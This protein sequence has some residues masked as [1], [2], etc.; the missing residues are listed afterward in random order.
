MLRDKKTT[1]GDPYQYFRLQ[2]VGR[3]TDPM[4]LKTTSKH[5]ALALTGWAF[6]LS[7]AAQWQWI[8]KDGRKVFSDR[9]PTADIKD[10]D[11]I[12]QPVGRGRAPA[13]AT[14]TEGSEATAPAGA[15]VAKVNANTPKIS[16]KDAELQAR[17][18][19]L[20]DEEAA[21]KKADEEN[22]ALGKADNCERGKKGLASLQS[23]VRISTVDAKGERQFM[24]DNTR[25]AESKRLQSIVDSDCK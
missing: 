12:K 6:A 23:G 11:I 7:A 19:K 2:R 18:K 8:D 21:K 13:S 17:K 16:G 15:A 20:E 24:D 4:N 1:A 10:K 25:A 14:T 22:L 3:Y 5:L 9:P